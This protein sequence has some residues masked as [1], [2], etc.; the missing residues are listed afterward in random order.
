MTT[1]L[2]WLCATLAVVLGCGCTATPLPEPP[3]ATVDFSRIHSPEISP[4][5]TSIGL[6]GDPGAGPPGKTLRV[7]NLDTQDPPVDVVIAAD[8]SFE[9]SLP[10]EALDELRFHTRAGR[11]RDLPADFVPGVG[12][13]PDPARVD[14]LL[15]LPLLQQDFGFVASAGTA[16]VHTVTLR[17][18]CA[19]SVSVTAARL[20]RA[21][22]AFAIGA[23]A[24]SLPLE[25]APGQ[26]LS[27]T[28]ELVP[29]SPGDV[30]EIFFVELTAQGEPARYPVTLYG[31]GT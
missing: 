3:A 20:R 13:V 27:W 28:L 12:P 31:D 21:S 16:A 22:A 2:R 14:C 30:E 15:L 17:N 7:T 5:T 29:V 26:N 9:I 4:T 25:L 11:E 1:S 23:G 10:G 19:V 24:P 8:G 6:V 18:E